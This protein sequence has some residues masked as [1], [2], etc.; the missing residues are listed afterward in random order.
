[1]TESLPIGERHFASNRELRK[2]PHLD[3]VSLPEIEKHS[4]SILIGSD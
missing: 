3:G 1:M 4:V 2:W